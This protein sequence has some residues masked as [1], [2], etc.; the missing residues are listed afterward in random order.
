MSATSYQ[1]INA[2]LGGATEG[3]SSSQFAKG[4]VQLIYNYTIPEPAS[5]SM[6]V[7]VLV[8]GFWIRRRFID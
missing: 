1:I 6:A 2:S 3:R 4:S 7:L 8:A 5:A